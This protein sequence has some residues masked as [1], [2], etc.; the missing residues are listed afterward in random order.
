MLY[1]LIIFII[2][3]SL[4][5]FYGKKPITNTVRYIMGIEGFSMESKIPPN[6]ILELPIREFTFKSSFNSAIK[7][8]VASVDAIKHVLEKGCR[9]LDLEIYTRDNIEYVSYSGDPE[10]K[11]LDTENS[12]AERLSLGQAFSTIA[13]NAFINLSPNPGD[14]LFI[15]LRIKNNSKDAY[16]RIAQM[17]DSSFK[18][19]L[20]NAEVNR[21]TKLK[22]IMGKVVII[23]DLQ[24]SPQY[25]NDVKCS[26]SVCHRL[27]DYVSIEAGSVHLPKY[28]YSDLTTLPAK[29]VSPDSQ[30]ITTD[31]KSF[32]MITPSQVE[33]IKPIEPMTVMNTWHPQFLLV[34]YGKDVDQYEKIFNDYGASIVPMAH[35]VKTSYSKNSAQ[36]V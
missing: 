2:V 4:V 13:G 10:F 17:I 9:L 34:K 19:R 32:M 23:I 8:N 1:I 7:D 29:P 6:D 16:S 24:S 12:P 11:S 15:M 5:A 35:I 33:Q 21:G 22:S 27:E 30:F 25:K 18:T 14:P 36:D 3:V 26:T 28:T 31:I 20:Y